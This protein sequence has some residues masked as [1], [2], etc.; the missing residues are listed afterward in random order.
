MSKSKGNAVDPAEALATYGADAIRW[1]FCNNSAPWLPNRFSPRAVTEGQ[2]KFLSTLYN[3]YSF[4]VL[5]AEIDQFDPTKHALN[6]E[7]LTVMDRWLLSRLH[8]LIRE[9]D[10]HL[11]HYRI[12]ETTRALDS[13]V[14]E[15]S[16]WYVRR[17]RERFW[18][19]E[20]TDDKTAAYMTLYTALVT[21]SKLAAPIVPFIS[22]QIYRNLV[23]SVD[24]SAPVSVHLCDYPEAD[25]R[26]I[27]PELEQGM[28]GVLQ[29]ATLGRA[30]R[31]AASIKNRQPL[32]AVYVKSD[33][34]L[35]EMFRQIVLDELNI[36]SYEQVADTSRFTSYTFKPQLK[37]VGQK[38]GR[39][40][41]AIRTALA[42]LDGSAAYAELQEKGG[43]TLRLPDGTVTLTEEELLIDASSAAGFAIQED[44]GVTVA[45]DTVLDDALIEE[46]FVRELVSKL[47]TMRKDAGFDVT[48]HIA[49]TQAGNSRI[50]EILRAN[51]AAVMGDVLADTL[52]FG[53][54]DGY[55][56]EWDVNGEKTSLGVKKL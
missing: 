43:V 9:V 26:W 3:T 51:R 17:S 16:N 27:D 19:T 4:Y 33:A 14:D 13:F 21:L 53:A 34:P 24:P 20:M 1:Y 28:A 22:E 12:T 6:P 55:T 50:E 42:E 49:V 40:V 15:L 37:V 31:N 52:E 38:Y 48:D 29:V 44:R 32:R 45:L 8:T 30:A 39:Q 7:H 36:K 5:Y 35:G 25:T 23:C 47:Q 54:V 11:D 56:A 46:G 18:G 2:R 41:G 10:G